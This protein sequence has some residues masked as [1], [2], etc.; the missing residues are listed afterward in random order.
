MRYRRY[1]ASERQITFSFGLL[2]RI[3][4]VCI[5][6]LVNYMKITLLAKFA[7]RNR[8]Y[9][10]ARYMSAYFRFTF[11]FCMSACILVETF[12]IYSSFIEKFTTPSHLVAGSNSFV[13]YAK[14]NIFF[15]YS[16]LRRNRNER[17][18]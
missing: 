14:I 1:I 5:Y 11:A 15:V 10:V 7:S 12:V 13:K 17:G 3:Y 4:T 6:I 2:P 8:L 18:N 16:Q 9:T